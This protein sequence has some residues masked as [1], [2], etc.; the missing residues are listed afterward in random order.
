MK[1]VIKIR[2]NDCQYIIDLERIEAIETQKISVNF[3]PKPELKIIVHM[4]NN[5]IN[6]D[7]SDGT[8]EEMNDDFNDLYA[9]WNKFKNDYYE[10]IS[11]PSIVEI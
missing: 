2:R 1:S 7:Y 6:I 8:I 11:Q 5:K 10:M 9:K 3:M 4:S